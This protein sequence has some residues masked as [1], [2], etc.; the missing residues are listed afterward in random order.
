METSVHNR[1]QHRLSLGSKGLEKNTTPTVKVK[2][3]SRESQVANN[4]GLISQADKT[5][6]D[7]RTCNLRNKINVSFKMKVA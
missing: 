4:L 2:G 1:N 7:L 3:R 6:R 5:Q